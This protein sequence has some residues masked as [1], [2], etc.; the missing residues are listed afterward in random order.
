MA[1]GSNQ[2]IDPGVVGAL[3][4]LYRF[5]NMR[6]HLLLENDDPLFI[7]IAQFIS[8][9][10]G[11]PAIK[12]GVSLGRLDNNP[13]GFIGQQ[14]I[15]VVPE[16]QGVTLPDQRLLPDIDVVALDISDT[17]AEPDKVQIVRNV[18]FGSL[19]LLRTVRQTSLKTFEPFVDVCHVG[20]RALGRKRLSR[21][22]WSTLRPGKR[23]QS[24][25]QQAQRLQ[26]PGRIEQVDAA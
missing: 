8:V 20:G 10:T 11:L 16:F 13:I 17:A 3:S 21:S 5:I 2:Q 7:L 12:H 25:L 6:K 1:I 19:Q 9:A 15:A 4:A 26:H 18:G 14:C 24:L 23:C 22:S